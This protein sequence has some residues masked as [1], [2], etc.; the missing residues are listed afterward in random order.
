MMAWTDRH[1]RRFHRLLAPS[2]RLYSEMLVADALLAGDAGRLLAFDP[3]ERPLALQLGGNDRHKLAAAA[4]LAEAAGYDEIDLNVGCPSDRV[5]QG[6]FGACLMRQPSR[7]RDL[8]AA[9]VEAVSIPVTVKCRIGVDELDSEAF[10]QDFIATV[11]AAGCRT[12]IVHARKAWLSGI[13]PKDNRRV[14]PLDHPRVYRLK[15]TFPELTVIINGGIAG[16]AEV[17]RHLEYVDGVMLGRAVY[18]NPY[19]LAECE[20]SFSGRVPPNRREVLEKMIAYAAR[21]AKD[22]VPPRRIG[23]HLLG[24]YHGQPGGRAWRRALGAALQTSSG[25]ETWRRCLPALPRADAA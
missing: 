21:Q 12:F 13:S 24:L 14:P 23:R 2:A 4:R 7:V 25:P 10:F 20:Q 19:L 16:R 5:Q 18:H 17:H 9:L 1:C 15:Q 6:V 22:G 8:V 11:M 3:A